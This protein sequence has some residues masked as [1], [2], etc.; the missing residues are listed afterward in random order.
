VIDLSGKQK[1]Y[2]LEDIRENEKQ[3]AKGHA[4]RARIYMQYGAVMAVIMLLVTLVFIAHYYSLDS[5]V[6]RNGFELRE[7]SA[8]PI[9]TAYHL[10]LTKVNVTNID[11]LQDYAENLGETRIWYNT[12]YP[13]NSD[14]GVLSY[15][16]VDESSNTVYF[17]QFQV[18]EHPPSPLIEVLPMLVAIAVTGSVIF[19][20]VAYYK[21]RK[22]SS[23]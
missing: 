14:T 1:K 6:L 3:Y 15:Y 11:V 18:I 4:S 10:N 9:D 21:M 5:Q 12:Y 23:V 22:E 2:D 7:H 8:G 13:S 19:G 17:V 16:F 20:V